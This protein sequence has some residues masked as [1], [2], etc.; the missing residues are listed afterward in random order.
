MLD[1][2][3]N[4]SFMDNQLRIAPKSETETK[5]IINQIIGKKKIKGRIHYLVWWKKHLR[6]DAT[7]EPRQKLIDDGLINMIRNFDK[8]NK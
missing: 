6:K 7:Y 5:Y 2:M 1:G 4:V 3:T 8:S